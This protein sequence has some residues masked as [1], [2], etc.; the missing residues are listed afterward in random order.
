MAWTTS[1]RRQRLPAHWPR[2]RA[3]VLKRD[4]VCKVC[5][6]RPSMQADHIKPGDDHSPSNLQGICTP[7]H[8]DKTQKE[9]MQARGIHGRLRPPEPHPGVGGYPP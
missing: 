8:K 7:C 4:P 1:D 9:S 2:L 5:G 6:R 3:M